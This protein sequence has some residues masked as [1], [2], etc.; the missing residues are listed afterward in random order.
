MSAPPDATELINP[1]CTEG[2][3]WLSG[4][5]DTANLLFQLMEPTRLISQHRIFALLHP[6]PPVCGLLKR[7]PRKPSCVVAG[8]TP[9]ALGAEPGAAVPGP[10]L[11]AEPPPRQARL[12][13]ARNTTV[14][15]SRVKPPL[16]LHPPPAAAASTLP[17]PNLSIL[18]PPSYAFPKRCARGCIARCGQRRQDASLPSTQPLVRPGMAIALLPAKQLAGFSPF[19]NFL[20]SYQLAAQAMP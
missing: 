12:F 3:G 19:F 11:F 7:D 2:W 1:A 20:T 15:N 13:T 17:P 18:I 5:E 4:G 14:K 9:Q 16:P 8:R 10:F 6:D